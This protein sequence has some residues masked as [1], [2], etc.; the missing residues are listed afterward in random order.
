MLEQLIRQNRRNLRVERI[1][2]TRFFLQIY[3]FEDVIA[4]ETVTKGARGHNSPGA[5]ELWGC[6]ITTGG[7]RKSQHCRKYF[8]Q[9]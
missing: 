7:A 6:R 5:E 8:L 9:L 4:L 2:I 3:S 1:S